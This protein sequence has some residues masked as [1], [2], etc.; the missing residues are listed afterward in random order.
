MVAKVNRV[1]TLFLLNIII[2]FLICGSVRALEVIRDTELE[3]F[4]NDILEILLSNNSLITDDI[5]VYFINSD[6]INAFVTGGTNLFINTELIISAED[7]REYAAVIAHELAHIISGHVFRTSE[8]ISNISGK[9]MPIYLLG[10]LGIIAGSTDAGFAGVMVGQAAVTDSFT[11]YSR[12]QEAAADQK[13]VSILCKSRINASYLSSF[14]KTLETTIPKINTNTENYRSTHPLPQD[15]RTWIQLALNNNKQCEFEKNLEL[16]KRFNLL[17]AKLFGFTHSHEETSAVYNSS[18]DKDLYATA[19]SSYLNGDL[20]QSIENLEK[21]I[22]KHKNNPFFKELI[23]EIYFSSQKYDEAIYFQKEAIN[24]LNV[25][26]DIY[27]MILGN[28]LLSTQEND[29]IKESIYFLK[30]SIQLNPRNAYSWYLLAK[31]YALIDELPLANYATAERY[32]LIGEKSLSYDF[33]SKAI[34][35]IEKSSPEWYRSYDLLEI[36]KKEV[37]ANTN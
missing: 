12:T 29:K 16:E 3:E 24:S 9:A 28:Y 14:L 33:A 27:S 30:K 6:Q 19:V 25:N 35:Y 31:S 1:K 21:L 15:R 7:Y 32:Y 8:E 13:A 37:P 20:I 18:S 34:K 5:N 11:Y 22:A 26:N 17:K 2:F 4:T 10:L 23:G 36:L